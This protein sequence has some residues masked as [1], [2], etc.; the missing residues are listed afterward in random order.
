MGYQ[1]TATTADHP[2]NTTYTVYLTNKGPTKARK[3][4]GLLLRESQP[5]FAI[6]DRWHAA[7]TRRHA[8]ALSIYYL[9]CAPDE[10]KQCGAGPV[11]LAKVCTLVY[12]LISVSRF[13]L[14]SLAM[15]TSLSSTAHSDATCHNIRTIQHACA[16]EYGC[17][18]LHVDT[19][20]PLAFT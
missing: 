6:T 2:I 18:W 9:A 5:F 20:V 10:H 17:T 3:G 7:T 16:L 14:P 8:A 19:P 13:F 4:Y 15:S 1:H 12:L 11:P